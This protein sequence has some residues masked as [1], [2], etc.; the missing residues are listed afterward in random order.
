M[1]QDTQAKRATPRLK[2][3]KA[4]PG[5][6]LVIAIVIISGVVCWYWLANGIGSANPLP[7]NESSL[8]EVEAQDIAPALT[9][10]SVP[11]ASLGKYQEGKDGCRQPLAWV[12]LVSAPGES[13]GHIRLISGT[14][15]SPVFEVSAKPVRVAIPYPAPYETGRGVLTVL[16]AGGSAMVALLPAW[17]VSAQDGKVTRPVTW[18][19]VKNCSVRNG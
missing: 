17:H 13:P 16:D 1:T 18:T 19:P 9:T 5:A 4:P 10:L 11:S 12:S 7:P 15:V 8:K 14:Y 2:S 3:Q 6:G